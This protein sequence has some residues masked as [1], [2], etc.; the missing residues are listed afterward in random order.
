MNYNQTVK[1]ELADSNKELDDFTYIVSH[2]LKEP[3]R[4]MDAFSKFVFDDYKDKLD[5]QG[6]DYLGRIRAN[7]NRANRCFVN[8]VS[9]RLNLMID[10]VS[11]A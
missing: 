3:L 10:R 8:F 7:A 11:L 1:Q 9:K 5:A 4:S 6:K 2:D